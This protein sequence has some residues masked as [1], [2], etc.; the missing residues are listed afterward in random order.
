MTAI[1]TDE[2]DCFCC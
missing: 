2:D 1:L